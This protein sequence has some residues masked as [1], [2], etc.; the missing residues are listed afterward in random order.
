MR[1]FKRETVGG[2]RVIALNRKFVSSSFNNI[3]KV[4]EKFFG[5]GLE[6]SCLFEKYF[7][8]I[9]KS[10]KNYENKYESRLI[11]YRK[12]NKE[13]FEKLFYKKPC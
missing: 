11:D 7:K 10:K 5:K 1:N 3:T 9:R 6:I 12:I 8:Y 13:L 2:G 4:L